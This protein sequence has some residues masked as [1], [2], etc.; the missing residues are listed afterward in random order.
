[1][2]ILSFPESAVPDDLRGQVVRLQDLAWPGD[3][4]SSLAPWHDPAL[5]PLS[6]LLV[7]DDQRVLS[8]LDILSKDLDHEG[9]RFAASGISTTVTDPE[10]RGH[11][12]GRI[13]A[14]A[15]QEMMQAQGADLGIFTCDTSLRA[16]Y[17][18][19]GW[20]ELAGTVLVGG[21][22][23]DPFPSDQ[24]G[25]DKV[26]MAAFFTPDAAAARGSFVGARVELY[27]GQIDKLW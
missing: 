7:D 18:S 4:P 12:F 25:F 24:S 10:L 26:T 14:E 16:F 19:A 8:A 22:A 9:Q 2:Q 20:S 23:A 27:P 11:G 13:I 3:E 17:S 5:A 15:A 1:M 6:V 21:T